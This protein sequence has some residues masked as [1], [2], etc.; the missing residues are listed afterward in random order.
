MCWTQ[1]G[2]QEMCYTG[3][4]VLSLFPQEKKAMDTIKTDKE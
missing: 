2:T 4:E 1:N 3:E